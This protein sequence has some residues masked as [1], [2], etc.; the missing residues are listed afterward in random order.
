MWFIHTIQNKTAEMSWKHWL[1]AWDSCD[2]LKAT[3]AEGYIE[4]HTE[5]E[6]QI[7]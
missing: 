2:I 6:M 3:G 4:L 1:G 5:G 7:V